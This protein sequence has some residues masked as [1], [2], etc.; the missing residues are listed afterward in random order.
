K[1][2]QRAMGGRGDPHIVKRLFTA[3]LKLPWFDPLLRDR[4]LQAGGRRASCG[5]MC[6]R[7]VRSALTVVW[8][9]GLARVCYTAVVRG[10]A[11]RRDRLAASVRSSSFRRKR[12]AYEAPSARRRRSERFPWM[13]RRATRWTHWRLPAFGRSLWVGLRLRIW[14]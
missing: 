9:R 5:Y 8:P 14:L 3:D 11:F 2:E 10:A 6:C 12:I 1:S 13:L 4:R 7:R